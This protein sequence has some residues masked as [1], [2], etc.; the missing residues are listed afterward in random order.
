MEMRT[1]HA[2]VRRR[3]RR[4][5]GGRTPWVKG[6]VLALLTTQPVAVAL[7]TLAFLCLALIITT[8]GGAYLTYSNL[9]RNLPGPEVVG[10]QTAQAFKTTKI[11]DRTGQTVLYEIYDP[12]GGNRTIVPLA[13]IPLNL[14]LATIALEDKD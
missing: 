5:A 9:V 7:N 6:I 3:Q 11:Y 12:H 2:V 10:E 13:Q 14:R 1:V 4:R 8:V